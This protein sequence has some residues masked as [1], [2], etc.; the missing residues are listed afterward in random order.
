M[1]LHCVLQILVN[2]YKLLG[3]ITSNRP[4]LQ[5]RRLTSQ[6]HMTRSGGVM[7]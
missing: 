2:F 7:N 1:P 5:I 3:V 4:I 6:G